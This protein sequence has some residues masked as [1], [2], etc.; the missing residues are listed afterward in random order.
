MDNR[1][2][3]MEADDRWREAAEKQK[4]ADSLRK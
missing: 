3:Q 4:E 1:S 2:K